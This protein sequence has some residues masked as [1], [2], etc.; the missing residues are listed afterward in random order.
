MA[1]DPQ[2]DHVAEAVMSALND[3]EDKAL[4]AILEGEPDDAPVELA[5]V[6]AALKS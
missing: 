6:Q 1:S 3:Y 5:A 2:A 4:L